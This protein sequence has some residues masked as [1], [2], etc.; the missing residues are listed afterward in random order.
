MRPSSADDVGGV[1]VEPDDLVEVRR[2]LV[3]G[4]PQVRSAHLD[5]LATCPQPGERQGRVGARADHQVHLLREVLQQ[6]AHVRGDRRAVG[7][8]VVVEHEAEPSRQGT[9]LVEDGGEDGGDRRV[10]GLQER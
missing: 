7:E 10:G 4:E 2:H 5:Q 8:V 9:E 1:Q 3:E 6:E